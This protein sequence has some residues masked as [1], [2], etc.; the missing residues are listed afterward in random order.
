MKSILSGPLAGRKTRMALALAAL[1]VAGT[2]F[3][4]ALG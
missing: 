2:L 4:F 3:F 1:A